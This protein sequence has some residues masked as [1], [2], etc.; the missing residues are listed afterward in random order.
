MVAG[1]PSYFQIDDPH[2]PSWW[3]TC[4]PPISTASTRNT[5]PQSPPVVTASVRNVFVWSARTSCVPTRNAAKPTST[6]PQA[7]IWRPLPV[8]TAIT[9]PSAA[10]NTSDTSTIAGGPI[11]SCSGTASRHPRAAP[12]RSQKY[13]L[14]TSAASTTINSEMITPRAKNT[15]VNASASTSTSNSSSAALLKLPTQI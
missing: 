11:V 12:V 9:N 4:R 10:N 13:S 2:N 14:R 7:A 5:A 15:A 3:S 1:V 6:M 8:D